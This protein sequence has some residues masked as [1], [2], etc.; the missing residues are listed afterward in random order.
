MKELLRE[1]EEKAKVLGNKDIN[2]GLY[3]HDPNKVAMYVLL[4]CTAVHT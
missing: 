4:H 3:S 1:E 2:I